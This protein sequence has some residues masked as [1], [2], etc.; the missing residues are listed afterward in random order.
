MTKNKK[1]Y[2]YRYIR[3]SLKCVWFI[4]FPYEIKFNPEQEKLINITQSNKD[5]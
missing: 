4:L 5:K 3:Y 2:W 1:P